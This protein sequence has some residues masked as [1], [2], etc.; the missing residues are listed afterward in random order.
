MFDKLKLSVIR[1][2]VVIPALGRLGSAFAG[3]LAATFPDFASPDTA[4][5]IGVGVAVGCALAYDLVVDWIGR[6]LAERKGAEK[7]KRAA[8]AAG[9]NI[10]DRV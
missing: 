2:N 1:D 4:Q 9:L 10:V 6:K 7:V 3:Y 5:K 8:R